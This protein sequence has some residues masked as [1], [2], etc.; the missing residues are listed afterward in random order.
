[1]TGRPLLV[2]ASPPVPDRRSRLHA[3]L[4]HCYPRAWRERYA[5]EFLALLAS[6]PLATGHVVDIL[7]GAV[8][9][10]LRP[11]LG[12]RPQHGLLA[13]LADLPTRLE[14][15]SLAVRHGEVRTRPIGELS[16]RAFLRRM[17]GAGTALL[18]LEFLGGTLAFLWPQFREGLG[19]TFRLGM[20]PEIIAAQPSF[21]TGTPYAYGPAR[22]FLV[23]VPAATALAMGREASVSDPTADQLLALWRKCPHLGCLV[24]E[25]CA[26]V[27]RFRCRCHG[28]TYNILGEKLKQ[29]P[30]ERG[31]D[32]FAV[33]IDDDGTVLVDTSQITRGEPNRGPDRLTFTD[34]HPWDATC[35]ER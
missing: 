33:R 30:A 2:H 28:S 15:P 34:P 19:A 7:R 9:A 11:Q 14:D 1:M 25:P 4:L 24:P 32:R 8:D 22:I 17:L 5:A 27:S 6:R 13:G 20:L 29:G 16:R 21:A 3:L 23:N 12:R 35:A 26:S 18:S 10:R 31:M